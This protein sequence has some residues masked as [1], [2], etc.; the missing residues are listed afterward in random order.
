MI[1]SIVQ[2]A[3]WLWLKDYLKI[4]E[5]RREGGSRNPRFRIEVRPMASDL[6]EKACAVKIRCVACGRPINPIRKRKAES[7]RSKAAHLYYA[8]CCPLQVDVG[9][10]R[11]PAARDEYKRIKAALRVSA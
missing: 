11:S 9:C 8:A 1:T 4:E 3:A 5:Y 10:S 2:H 7:K 6:V